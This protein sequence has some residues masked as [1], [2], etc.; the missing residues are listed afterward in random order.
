MFEELQLDR[1]LLLGL[2]SL[3]FDQAT[4]VQQS[5]VPTA[6]AGSDIRIRAETGSGKTLAYLLPA[7]QAILATPPTRSEGAVALVLVPT[8][9]LVRQ[10]LK[11]GRALLAKSGIEVQGLSGGADFKYQAARLR[12][13]P[14]IVVATPGRLREHCESATV[15]FSTLRIFVLDEADRMLEMGF[16]D[17]VLAINAHLPAEKQV[18][19][20]SATLQ[21]RRTDDL[22]SSLLADAVTLEFSAAREVNES[23]EHQ[24]VLVDDRE[25]RDAVLLALLKARPYRRALVFANRRRDADRLATLLRGQG[26]RCAPLHGDLSTEQRKQVMT[27]FSDGKIDIVCAS[28]LAARGLDVKELD[29]VINYE[30][31][32]SGNDYLHRTGRTGRAGASGVAVSLVGAAEWN[33][34]A[35]IQ[36]YLHMRMEACSV[37]GLKARYKG[38]KKLK[39]SGKKA[40]TGKRKQGTKQSARRTSRPG[41]PATG[42]TSARPGPDNDGF[43]PLMKKPRA[44]KD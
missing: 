24:R 34:L 6:L 44:P 10:V 25:H 2:E 5:V 16:R 30:L 31:P 26:L 17:D 15:D 27:Q 9:E 23:V 22:A 12:R 32:R 39:N 40:A 13:N 4:E 3:G 36:R 28:D 11:Q 41:R 20:L 38:P 18:I 42:K 29:L 33:L 37:P 14:E 8:R 21:N 7:A 19:L 35:S 1:R 43:A